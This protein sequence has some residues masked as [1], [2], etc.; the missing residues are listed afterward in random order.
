[1]KLKRNYLRDERERMMLRNLLFLVAV[2][3]TAIQSGGNYFPKMQPS[4]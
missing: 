4:Y 2:L 3:G 1:M